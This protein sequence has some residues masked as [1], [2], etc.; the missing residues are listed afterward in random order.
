MTLADESVEAS[1]YRN[2]VTSKRVRCRTADGLSRKIVPAELHPDVG[3][4]VLR[5]EVRNAHLKEHLRT[6]HIHT[7]KKGCRS[8]LNLF[9]SAYDDRILRVVRDVR[10]I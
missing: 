7:A 10:S 1:V 8:M 3:L 9:V 5:L 4:I 2:G 6:G